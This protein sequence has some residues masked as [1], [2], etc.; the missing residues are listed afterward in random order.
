MGKGKLNIGKY[1]N[2]VKESYKGGGHNPLDP[3]DPNEK[4]KIT[5]DSKKR[6][7]SKFIG[8]VHSTNTRLE[9]KKTELIKEIKQKIS[10][11]RK[12]E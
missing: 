5:V 10:F 4:F 9:A 11:E 6:L 8:S 2:I 7:R 1:E 12:M 3:K